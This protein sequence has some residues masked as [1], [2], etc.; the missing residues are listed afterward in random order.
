MLTGF[1]HGRPYNANE[2]FVTGTFDDWGKTVKLDRKG[3]AFEKE[4]HLPST[5]ENVYYKVLFLRFP[6]SPWMPRSTANMEPCYL[7]FDYYDAPFVLLHLL[8]S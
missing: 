6:H 5:H 2:V 3:D 7:E 4:V 8:T 1:L